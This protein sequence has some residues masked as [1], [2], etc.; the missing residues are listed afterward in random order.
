[1]TAQ[2]TNCCQGCCCWRPAHPAAALLQQ[3]LQ[4]CRPRHLV[5]LT[6]GGLP[7]SHQCQQ[8]LEKQQQQPSLLL[9]LLLPML[10]VL[11]MSDFLPV[12]C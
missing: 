8:F 10:P 9:L 3:T 7:A 11:L 1:M 2:Q 12:C 5:G 6:R 4:A